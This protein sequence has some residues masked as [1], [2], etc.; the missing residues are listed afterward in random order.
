MNREELSDRLLS[1]IFP[2]RCVVCS[3]VV[4]YDM[5]WCGCGLEANQQKITLENGTCC[6]SAYSYDNRARDLI[7]RFKKEKDIRTARFIANRIVESAALLGM[8]FDFDAIVPVPPR[9]GAQQNDHAYRIAKALSQDLALPL[10]NSALGR[11]AD[12]EIQHRLKYHERRKNAQKS[13]Y[14][15]QHPLEEKRVLLVDD[16]VT[17]GATLSA[18]AAELLSSGV[19][20]VFAVAFAAT[21][22]GDEMVTAN[23]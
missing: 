15:K 20:G 11:R 4:D 6:I 14:A 1:I 23:Q 22:I 18:C 17:T 21:S 3:R 2:A 19:A 5:L 8:N 13:Y 12:S 10:Y 16:I 9:E 7:L